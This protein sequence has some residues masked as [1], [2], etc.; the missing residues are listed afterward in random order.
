MA[1]AYCDVADVASGFPQF[2][3]NQK[4]SIQDSQIQGWIADRKAR[5]RSALLTRGYDP[6]VLVLT[7]DQTSFL[8]AL[9]RD[10]AM[11]D[12]GD[13]LQGTVTLQAGEYSVAQARRKSYETVLAE[14]KEGLHDQLFQPDVSRTTDVTPQLRGIGGAE[15]DPFTTPVDLNQNRFFGKNQKF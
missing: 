6:D 1:G 9:N 3:R 2:Q 5:I 7:E 11:A 14:I 12:L 15:T 13:A 10:G 4:G 8:R